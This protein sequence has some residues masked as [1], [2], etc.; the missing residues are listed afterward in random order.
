MKRRGYWFA[1]LTI[2]VK[3]RREWVSLGCQFLDSR[4]NRSRHPMQTIDLASGRYRVLVR[5]I[6][7]GKRLYQLAFVEAVDEYVPAHSDAFMKSF[8]LR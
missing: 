3:P 6:A 8:R 7:D 4:D 1:P 5:A 2:A